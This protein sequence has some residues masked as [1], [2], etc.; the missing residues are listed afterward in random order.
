MK[1]HLDNMQR[2]IEGTPTVDDKETVGKIV[3]KVLKG[4][5]VTK[6]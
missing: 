3:E 5:D 1:L 4:E 6:T 2:I